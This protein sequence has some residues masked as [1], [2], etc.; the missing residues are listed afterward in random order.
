[1]ASTNNITWTLQ[2]LDPAA[3]T[4]A[5]PRPITLSD[6]AASVGDFRGIGRLID[7][8]QITIG[9]PVA[10][11]RQLELRNTHSTAA[12][13][14]VW[15]PNGGVSATVLVLGPGDG[16]CFWHQSTGATLGI[17]QLKLQSDTT[18]ATYEMFLGG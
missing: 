14:V 3:K 15:T 9:L 16:I 1:M 17:S 11:V 12:I 4:L 8:T 18:N 10:Q 6:T 5:G 7:L 13:T 2:Q